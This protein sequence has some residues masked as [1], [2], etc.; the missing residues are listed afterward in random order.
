MVSKGS[1]YNEKA[2][3]FSEK[4]KKNNLEDL[5]EE[6]I[7]EGSPRTG[8]STPSDS[9]AE[10]YDAKMMQ[11]LYDVIQTCLVETTL[12]LKEVS[13]TLTRL[14]FYTCGNMLQHG[15]TIVYKS[16]Y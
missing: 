2:G 5:K 10:D 15:C 12:V 8:G 7:L 14:L 11:M 16:K 3:E 9:K 1:R 4:I 13:G 6:N